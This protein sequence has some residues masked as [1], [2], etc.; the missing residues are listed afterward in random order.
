MS[1]ASVQIQMEKVKDFAEYYLSPEQRIIFCNTIWCRI[2]CHLQAQ[3]I[4]K[5][6]HT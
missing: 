4:S 6:E 3:N 1:N 5:K 2:K